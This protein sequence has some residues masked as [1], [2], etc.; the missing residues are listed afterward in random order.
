MD[1]TC[2]HPC[3]LAAL[4]PPWPVHACTAQYA[5]H[6]IRRVFALVAQRCTSQHPDPDE[7]NRM[8]IHLFPP[9]R[10]AWQSL[11]SLLILHYVDRLKVHCCSA[12]ICSLR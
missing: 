6:S 9:I 7:T 11:Y 3:M 8:T 5:L 2:M 12:V 4:A 1:D 10:L